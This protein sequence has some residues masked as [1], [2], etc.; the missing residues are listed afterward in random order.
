MQAYL[1]MGEELL[2]QGGGRAM[3]S[4]R[5]WGL[6][7]SHVHHRRKAGVHLQCTQVVLASPLGLTQAKEEQ[8]DVGKYLMLGALGGVASRGCCLH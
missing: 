3:V 1:N 6:G 8:M 4:S 7:L 2:T 5:G